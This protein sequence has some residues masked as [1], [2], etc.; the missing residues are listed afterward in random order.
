M[1]CPEFYGHVPMNISRLNEKMM[2]KQWLEWGTIFSV[3]PREGGCRIVK[4]GGVNMV[5]P[6]V[7]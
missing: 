5:Y 3:K 4:N 1:L 6:L 2:T 7:N